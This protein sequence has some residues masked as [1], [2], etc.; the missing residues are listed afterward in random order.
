MSN[1]IVWFTG[2]PASGKTSLAERARERLAAAG[3][4]R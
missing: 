1:A 3:C 4:A 2:L